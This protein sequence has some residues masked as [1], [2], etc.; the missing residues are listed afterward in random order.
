MSSAVGPGAPSPTVTH[1]PAA[2]VPA[3]TQNTSVLGGGFKIGTPSK[4]AMCWRSSVLGRCFSLPDMARQ[5]ALAPRRERG[6][7]RH[8]ARRRCGLARRSPSDAAR[9][10]RARWR[11]KPGALRPAPPH[12][13]ASANPVHRLL[14]AL[15]RRAQRWLRASRP[16]ISGLFVCGS[17]SHRRHICPHD[18]NCARVANTSVLALKY[19]GTS[20]GLADVEN[21][22][23]WRTE[24]SVLAALFREH[25]KCRKSLFAGRYC[26]NIGVAFYPVG[27]PRISAPR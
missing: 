17:G 10:C 13:G 15:D 19:A 20:I 16:A 6:G 1:A 4:A 26:Q 21:G 3:V 7:R 12:L 9:L 24:R 5:C 23:S 18:V 27:N 2:G 14:F 25:W 22:G 11:D 8:A